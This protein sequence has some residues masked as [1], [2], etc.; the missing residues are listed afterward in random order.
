[1]IILSIAIS[2]GFLYVAFTHTLPIPPCNTF[3]NETACGDGEDMPCSYLCTWDSED[4][5]CMPEP[6]PYYCSEIEGGNPGYAFIGPGLFALVC[7]VWVSLSSCCLREVKLTDDDGETF[8]FEGR[9]EQH[10]EEQ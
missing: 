9:A 10:E 1:L 5:L 6:Y 4:D 8:E 2:V 3:T 7:F